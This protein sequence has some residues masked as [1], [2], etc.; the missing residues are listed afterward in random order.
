MS[1]FDYLKTVTNGWNMTKDKKRE[2]KK[3]WILLTEDNCLVFK[4]T[5][6]EAS[7]NKSPCAVYNKNISGVLPGEVSNNSRSSSRE[8]SCAS[9]P[10]G[11]RGEVDHEIK[12]SRRWNILSLALC[13]VRKS[14]RLNSVCLPSSVSL[15]WFLRSSPPRLSSGY[16]CSTEERSVPASPQRTVCNRTPH[17]RAA[18]QTM[19]LRC[20]EVEGTSARGSSRAEKHT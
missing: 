19:C 5:A 18:S 14:R 12:M 6:S 10:A 13:L 9:W 17:C 2:G 4:W 1:V 20:V 15:Q 11:R 16:F 7:D 3:H 8:W